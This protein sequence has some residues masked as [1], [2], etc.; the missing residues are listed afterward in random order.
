MLEIEEYGSGM[1]PASTEHTVQRG[2]L[3]L[4]R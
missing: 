1:V 3:A 4:N 2:R